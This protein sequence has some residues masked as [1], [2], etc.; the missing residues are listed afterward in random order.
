MEQEQEQ[1]EV[2]TPET[3]S[4]GLD[5]LLSGETNIESSSEPKTE[6]GIDPSVEQ[7]SEED[8][9]TPIEEGERPE[10]LPE[11]FKTADDMA[12]AY[13]HLESKF[14]SFTGAPE[15]YEVT[16]PEGIDFEFYENSEFGIDKFQDMAKEMNLDQEGFDKVMNFYINSESQRASMEMKAR[17]DSVY[18]VFGGVDAA[19]KE[20]PKISA[21]VKGA[22]GAEGIDVYKDAAS[23]SATAA[24]SAIKLAGMLINKLDGEYTPTKHT[25][26]AT[27]SRKELA[28]ALLTPEYAKDPEYKAHIDAE[29]KRVYNL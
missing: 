17:E 16:K 6:E 1:Q 29:Y 11:K 22:L 4:G 2:T 25:P 19:Q 13:K 3:E 21:R 5:T 12:E 23:G 20:I 26:Q 15:K 28:S 27:M 10:W 18:E 14:G 24:A 9:S 7:E 8:G